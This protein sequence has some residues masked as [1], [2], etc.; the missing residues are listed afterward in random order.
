MTSSRTIL[1]AYPHGD[2]AGGSPPDAAR[3]RPPVL[4]LRGRPMASRW[5]LVSPLLFAAVSSGD[6][7]RVRATEG[8]HRPDVRVSGLRRRVGGGT[9]PELRRAVRLLSS[10]C[11]LFGH[12]IERRI[13]ASSAEHARTG[14]RSMNSRT[15]RS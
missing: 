7:D 14:R 13:R 15:Y 5:R 11:R 10:D 1:P 4:T 3:A 12:G 6:R 8:A 2:L 9:T